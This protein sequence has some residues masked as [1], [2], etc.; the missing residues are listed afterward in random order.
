MKWLREA[1][2][3]SPCAAPWT[4][5]SSLFLSLPAAA[6]KPQPHHQSGRSGF[7][8]LQGSFERA[9]VFCELQESYTDD[10]LKQCSM[11]QIIFCTD[12]FFLPVLW[13][14]QHM[15]WA[16]SSTVLYSPQNWTYL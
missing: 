1:G 12:S 4:P 11:D 9:P 15:V 6:Q 7:E 13:Q 5:A 3:A 16:Q 8:A 2:S 14:L 10:E